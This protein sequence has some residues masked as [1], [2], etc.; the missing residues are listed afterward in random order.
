MDQ[1][2]STVIIAVIT[3]VFS[4]ITLLIQKKQDKVVSKIDEQTLFIAQEKEIKKKINKKEAEREVLIHE[5]M[6][7]I[8]DTN[9]H[10]LR[11]THAV[12]ESSTSSE[13]VMKTSEILKER[14]N[15]ASDE[16]DELT[17]QY[18]LILN[19]SEEYEKEYKKPTISK[20]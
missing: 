10:I 11:N 16:I 20:K 15:T 6:I 13:E 2:L 12:G 4:V 19:L 9:I 14:F 5:I 17:K 18:E 1:Y 8:L 3:G 7:L